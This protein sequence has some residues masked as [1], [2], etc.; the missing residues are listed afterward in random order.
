MDNMDF[1]EGI[2]AEILTE[3]AKASDIVDAIKKRYE[4]N[5]SYRADDDPKGSGPRVVQPVAYGL[6]KK[7]NPVMRAF[8]PYG[9]TKTRVP[10]WKFFRL[11]RITSWKPMRNRRFTEPPA[12]QWRAAG[13]VGDFNPNGDESMSEVYVV[14]D[15]VN[16]KARYERG[17]LAKYNAERAARKR[18]ADPTAKFRQ[19]VGNASK[20]S[21][22]DY[23]ARN[24]ADWQREKDRRD[25]R[26]LAA[27]T[28]NN[29]GN[30]ASVRDMERV[31]NFPDT[32]TDTNGPILKGDEPTVQPMTGT[33][34]NDYG[35]VR[36][37]GPVYQEA[38]A[39]TG[40]EE[41]KTEDYDITNG[42][43]DVR[44]KQGSSTD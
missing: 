12:E 27:D 22:P 15:F 18:E 31:Q 42:N 16:T 38:N 8:E 39:D 41:D 20:V 24:L 4:V 21:T 11:D 26:K 43:N 2:I 19:N 5:M 9:D 10:R 35:N 40:A 25:A 33:E 44:L 1:L 7:G 30:S 28:R 37:S 13:A 34:R 32:E 6:T 3:D 29:R 23:I 14:A 36:Q 17:G